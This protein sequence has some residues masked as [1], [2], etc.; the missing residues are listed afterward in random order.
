VALA[1]FLSKQA[2]VHKSFPVILCEEG[3]IQSYQWFVKVFNYSFP[4]LIEILG[5]KVSMGCERVIVHCI[6]LA[7]FLEMP[8]NNI[9]GTDLVPEY[10]NF[11]QEDWFDYLSDN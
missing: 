10:T 9:M 8:G 3:Y 6:A 1:K 4:K 5:G 11:K 2:G 7:L